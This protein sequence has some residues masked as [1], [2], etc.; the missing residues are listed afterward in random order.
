MIYTYTYEVAT[1]MHVS[2]ASAEEADIR[3]Q[4]VI[5]DMEEIAGNPDVVTSLCHIRAEDGESVYVS[6]QEFVPY[7]LEEFPNS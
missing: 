2:A 3:L 1:L 6:E 4:E 5:K 7:P